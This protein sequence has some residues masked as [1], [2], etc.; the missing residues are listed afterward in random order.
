MCCFFFFLIII[1]CLI[2]A[3]DQAELQIFW[4]VPDV[5]FKLFLINLDTQVYLKIHWRCTR[6]AMRQ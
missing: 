4:E 6:V 3:L 1:I 5:M 2:I